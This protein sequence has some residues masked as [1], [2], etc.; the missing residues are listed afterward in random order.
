MIRMGGHMASRRALSLA[1]VAALVSGLAIGSGGPASAARPMS[2]DPGRNCLDVNDTV[3]SN[4][5]VAGCVDR[6]RMDP[7][8]PAVLQNS[9]LNWVDIGSSDPPTPSRCEDGRLTHEDGWVWRCVVNG[10][11]HRLVRVK[12]WQRPV[13]FTFAHTSTAPRSTLTVTA[14][15]PLNGCRLTASDARL[16][17]GQQMTLSARS[18]RRALDATKVPA[19]KYSLRVTCKGSRLNASSDILVRADHS[20]LLRSDCIDAWHDGKYGDVVPGY[21]RRMEPAR[22]IAVATECAALTPL[23]YDEF[24]RVGREAYL[25]IGQIAEREVRRVS[26]AEGIPIC[27]AIVDVFKPVD[28]VGRP[29]APRPH[30]NLGMPV[31][32]A[33]YL[34]DGYFPILFREWQDGPVRMDTIANCASGVQALRLSAGTWARCALDRL[35]LAPA[36]PHQMYPVYVFNRSG[37][38]SSYPVDEVSQSSVCIVWGDAIG[39]NV[40]GGVGRVFAADARQASGDSWTAAYDCQER[41]LRSGQFTNVDVDFAS[42]L[43]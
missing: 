22:A 42:A 28:T 21:G 15:T 23:T 20:M 8:Y 13:Q 12:P 38:P 39:N 40:S 32:I 27:E 1:L 16:L 19:G 25:R 33:G 18:A 36:D 7:A 43:K 14:N 2:P 26:A 6:A 9:G 30:P 31:P 29:V 11:E 3:A 17:T 41:A 37:C 10:D 34:P 4:G 24:Q 35:A 5:R